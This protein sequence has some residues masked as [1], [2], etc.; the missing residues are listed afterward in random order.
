[1]LV[2]YKVL[3]VYTV[4]L[5]KLIRLKLKVVVEKVLKVPISIFNYYVFICKKILEF[6][7][8]LKLY[9]VKI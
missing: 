2:F 5:K 4:Y 9:T 3:I 7:L 1:M 6:K 8:N